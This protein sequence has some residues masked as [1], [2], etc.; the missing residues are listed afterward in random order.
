M[1][2]RRQRFDGGCELESEVGGVNLLRV[3]PAADCDDLGVPFRN[4][5]HRGLEAQ[6][7]QALQARPVQEVATRRAGVILSE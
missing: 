2:P 6:A 4:A 1:A 3:R 5:R 7:A